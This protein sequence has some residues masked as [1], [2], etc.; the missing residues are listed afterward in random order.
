MSSRVRRRRGTE[1]W[2][3]AAVAC[4]FGTAAR[5][6]AQ[7]AAQI[8]DSASA[9][10]IRFD[11][12]PLPGGAAAL[13]RFLF[14]EVP[15]WIQIGGVIVG[16]IVAV[17]GGTLAWRRRR[18]TFTWLVTRSRGAQIALGATPVLTLGVAG[19]AGAWSWD[20]M[21]QDN[22]F[23]S[24]CHVMKGAFNRFR[25]SEHDKLECHAC[26]QQSIFASAQELYYWVLDRPEKIPEH[27]P[28]PN[29]ICGEC[30]E[31]TQ[32]DSAW[33]RVIATAGHAVHFKSD[34]SALKNLM[35]VDCHA[36]DVHAFKATDLSCKSSGCHE[37]IKVR[38]GAMADQSGLHCV[39]CH[40]F[41][42][43][44]SE[45]VAIDSTRKALVPARQECFSCHEMRA[46]L[47][48]RDL[49]KD[50]HQATCGT[51]HNPHD[52]A[53][54]G[55]AFDTCA[56]AGC[57]SSPDTLSAF[58]RGIGQHALDQCGSCHKPHSWKVES[59]RCQDC[60]RDIYR[61]GP[62]PLRRAD[63]EAP[64]AEGAPDDPP[65]GAP[66]RGPRVLEARS[67]FGGHA[68][69]GARAVDARVARDTVFDHARHRKVEC[70]S[71]HSTSRAHGTVSIKAPADCASCHHAAD[72]RAGTC[73]ACHARGELPPTIA[74]PTA[75]RV[76]G[77]AQASTRTL[78]FD[79]GQHAPVLCGRCH[80]N[81]ASQRVTT[82]CAECHENHHRA[83]ANCASCHADAR[84]THTRGTHVT[85]GT[86]HT[87][88]GTGKLPPT[89]AVCLA[90]HSAQREHKP[91]GDCAACHLAGWTP[92]P[93]SP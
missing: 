20:F 48:E 88:A 13:F 76:T 66:R 18:E 49:D 15:Q 84:A 67:A 6:G 85:C 32:A 42:R 1:S 37:D 55:K 86:C 68:P 26:H 63:T 79:H 44:V 7:S 70:T 56:S 22:D 17:V 72:A 24:S 74:V 40:D 39:T 11:Q 91:G 89:R 75:I 69:V 34:S 4:V 41:G 52:Q 3:L 19:G 38:L 9:D 73:E 93:S 83:T 35:C 27:A 61:R 78:S 36:K 53:K 50:P 51:C 46:K 57:H 23:C 8:H 33:K 14:S 59:T 5:V 16:A 10:S 43:P 54:A 29:R 47:A 58:H 28:V 2:F 25:V 71:C 81:D 45:V 82:T 87:G 62:I 64:A 80:A 77:K 90:C 65:F 21:M 31:Q 92:E 60:H 30:H 12:A